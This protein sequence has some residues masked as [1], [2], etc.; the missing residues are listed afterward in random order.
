MRKLIEWLY[1]ASAQAMPLWWGWQWGYVS[2][3]R[4]YF[5][6]SDAPDFV[7]WPWKWRLDRFDSDGGQG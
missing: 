5:E 4:M 7:G 3:A 1:L 6:H 2:N